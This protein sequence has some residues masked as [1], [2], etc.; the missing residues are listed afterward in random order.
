MRNNKEKQSNGKIDPKLVKRL[1]SE[2]GLLEDI[3]QS[4]SHDEDQMGELVNEFA[5]GIVAILKKDANFKRKILESA[6]LNPKFEEDVIQKI[7]KQ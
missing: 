6:I 2:E 3:V 4:V 1:F 5:E 7:R